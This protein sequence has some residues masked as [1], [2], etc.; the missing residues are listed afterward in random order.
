MKRP[1]VL[2]ALCALLAPLP[3]QAGEDAPVRND[4]ADIAAPAVITVSK[5]S[6]GLGAAID[7]RPIVRTTGGLRSVAQPLGGLP[8][9]GRLTSR[10]GMRAHPI[11]GGIRRHSGID[12]AAATGSPVVAPAAGT[13]TYSGWRGGYGLLVEVDHGGGVRTRF[14]HLSRLLVMPGQAVLG[15]QM[16]GL[17]GATGNATGAH[18]HYEVRRDGTAVD[19]LAAR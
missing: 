8:L 11:F 17:V 10:F 19:P 12:V 15:G 4:L 3:A 2:A 5:A 6:D 1:A 9:S 14:G 16:V 18:L 7:L 13:V